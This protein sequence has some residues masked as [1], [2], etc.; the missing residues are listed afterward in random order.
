[1]CSEIRSEC[2]HAFKDISA[3][4]A[5]L[6]TQ[7]QTMASEVSSVREAVRGN[8]DTDKSLVVRVARNTLWI[9]LII[10]IPMSIGTLTGIV[11]AIVKAW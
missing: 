3:S 8:G 11:I 2:A 9:K 7:V 5:T 1:M 10:G 4:L 6:N